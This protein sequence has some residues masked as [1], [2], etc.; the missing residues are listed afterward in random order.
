MQN[1]DIPALRK[2]QVHAFSDKRQPLM[3]PLPKKQQIGTLSNL[4]L[5]EFEGSHE[6][7]VRLIQWPKELV[8]FHFGRLYTKSYYLDLPRFHSMLLVHKETLKTVDIS[9]PSP[10]GRGRL[11]IASDFPHLETLRLSRWQMDRDLVFSRED[12]DALLASNLQTFGW[13]FGIYDQHSESWTDFGTKEA[14]WLRALAKAAAARK[15]A[16]KRIEI[17]YNPDPCYAQTEGDGYPWDRMDRLRD[18]IRPYGI[19]LEYSEPSLSRE[20]WLEAVAPK[21]VFKERRITHYFTP[22]R[23]RCQH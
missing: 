8:H 23:R 20:D 13:D 6:N 2:L 12:A 1:I 16:L 5:Y 9:Y 18:E 10:E 22:K 14:E 11:F 7:T 17:T 21:P 4:S 3:V 19:A 15:A